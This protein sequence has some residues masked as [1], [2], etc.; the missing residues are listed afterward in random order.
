MART[1]AGWFSVSSASGAGNPVSVTAFG[2]LTVQPMAVLSNRP[3]VNWLA[4][5][6]AGPPGKRR[7]PRV[8]VPGAM[9]WMGDGLV[10]AAQPPGAVRPGRASVFAR[11]QQRIVGQ[12]EVD[13]IQRE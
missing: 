2:V 7:R 13:L 4:S 10:L 6:I 1:A 3:R 8:R 11:Q 5:G 12:V 9:G